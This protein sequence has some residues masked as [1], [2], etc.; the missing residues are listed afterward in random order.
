MSFPNPGRHAKFEKAAKYRQPDLTLILENVHD[1]HNV[2]AVLRSAESIG[3]IEIFVLNTDPQ[4]YKKKMKLGKRTSS[5]ARKWVD[6]HLYND[7]QKCFSKVKE[8]YPNV[9]G[10]FLGETSK[11]LFELDFTEPV[12]ILFGNEHKGITPES[13]AHC[14]GLFTIPQF[15]FTQS[16]NISVACAITLYEA[17]RQRIVKG[18]YGNH[19]NWDES[20]Q[21]A[22]LANF[23]ERQESG[24]K[25][26]SVNVK[27]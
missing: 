5:G 12:A 27:K 21:T 18:Y 16:L 10:A 19:P 3:L 6:V 15:G 24:Y 8:K 4:L 14:T 2:G 23:I 26:H 7:A 22:M 13:L 1:T 20:K 17:C 9:L 25:A 11:S